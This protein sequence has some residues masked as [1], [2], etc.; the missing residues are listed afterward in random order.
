[1]DE[2]D[3][4]STSVKPS[5]HQIAYIL[6]CKNKI[7]SGSKKLYFDPFD[8]PPSGINVSDYY[9]KPVYVINI[10][11]KQFTCCDCKQKFS[12]D[13]WMS[14]YRHIHCLKTSCYLLQKN[15]KCGC[16]NSQTGKKR[17]I[18]GHQ[19][20]CSKSTPLFLKV[21]YPFYDTGK[22]MIHN[23]IITLLVHD[24]TTGK[25]F[26]EIGSTICSYRLHEYAAK[27]TLF[28]M[29]RDYMKNQNSIAKIDDVD[30]GAMDN[31][32][33]YN[34]QLQPS[35]QFLI[36]TFNK[37]IEEHEP[38]M[39]AFFNSIVVHPLQSFDATYNMSR[40]TLDYHVLEGDGIFQNKIKYLPKNGGLLISMNGTGQ[41]TYVGQIGKN[42]SVSDME[43]CLNSLKD[44]CDKLRTPYPN[45]FYVDNVQ[46]W[47]NTVKSVFGDDVSVLQ[48]IKHL[49]NR[50]LE[51]ASKQHDLY[52]QLNK[53]LH[54][55]FTIG[56]GQM[57]KQT[58]SG[59]TLYS[60]APLRSP[61]M[62]CQELERIV[63]YYKKE[64]KNFSIPL[65]NKDF[66]KTFENQKENI[67][68]YVREV[69]IDGDYRYEG[70]DGDIRVYRG[71]IV[72]FLIIIY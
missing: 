39:I 26:E 17:K 4:S 72:Y 58:R 20:V 45:Y 1:M 7:E 2:Y 18:A 65:F 24:A 22:A 51:C 71:I 52:G 31:P 36:D 60:K 12:A 56:D 15:Y 66:D 42:E 30:F 6:E 34:Q 54:G 38:E 35:D 10:D 50:I 61:E 5:T 41:I 33:G 3:D 19:L 29:T 48:D 49:I 23:E 14:S 63:N 44:R 32:L 64:D 57:P 53:D 25:S 46:T 27:R 37:F 8:E 69:Y 70:L 68:K 55:A 13:G 28:V 11:P 21:L 40:R 67:M 47:E 16:N 62:I 59:K 9:L 43:K